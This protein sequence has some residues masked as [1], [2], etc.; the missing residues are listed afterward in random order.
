MFILTQDNALSE[1]KGIV[2]VSHASYEDVYKVSQVTRYG[3]TTLGEFSS[4]N[5]ADK[6]II[7]IGKAIENEF[8]LFVIPQR[9]DEHVIDEIIS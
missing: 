2:R 7:A 3:I 5:I 1:L 8:P 4:K 9:R 6:V